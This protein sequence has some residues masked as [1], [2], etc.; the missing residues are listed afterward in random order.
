[1]NYSRAPTNP[2]SGSIPH[3]IVNV[4]KEVVSKNVINNLYILI[5]IRY[6]LKFNVDCFN[7]LFGKTALLSK[8][9]LTYHK[10][11]ILLVLFLVC[12]QLL[13]NNN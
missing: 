12:K 13:C 7:V 11:T 3:V 6:D 5:L 9:K 10:Q 2:C 4:Y 1:M 8:F